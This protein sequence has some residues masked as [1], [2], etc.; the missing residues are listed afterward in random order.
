MS[1]LAPTPIPRDP[2]AVRVTAGEV[3]D[4][5]AAILAEPASDLAAEADALARAHAVLREALNDN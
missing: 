4:R 3:S 2:R 5:I 1:P